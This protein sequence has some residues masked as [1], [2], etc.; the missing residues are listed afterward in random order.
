MSAG[1]TY[2]LVLDVSP[3]PSCNAYTNLTISA[4]VTSGGC[5]LGTG[6]VTIASLPYSSVA[7]LRVEKLMI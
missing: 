1:I 3:S 7:E 5:P 4:P 2:Y 6:A